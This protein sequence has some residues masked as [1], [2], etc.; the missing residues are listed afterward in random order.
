MSK[1][2]LDELILKMNEDLENVQK[3]LIKARAKESSNSKTKQEALMYIEKAEKVI[4]QA[5][6]GKINLSDEQVDR[7]KETLQKILQ[8]FRYT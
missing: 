6:T 1:D 5:E 4:E 2:N 3:S 8:L 7:I